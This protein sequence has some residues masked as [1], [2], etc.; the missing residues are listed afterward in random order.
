MIDRFSELGN[1]H[2]DENRQAGACVKA[3]LFLVSCL[4]H[5]L[6]TLR[7]RFSLC[8]I[9]QSTLKTRMGELVVIVYM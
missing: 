7:S 4:C 2:A 1:P 6:F 3:G 8:A 5:L 9:R